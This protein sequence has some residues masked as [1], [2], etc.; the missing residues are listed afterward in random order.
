MLIS[1][2]EF[3][4]DFVSR[5]LYTMMVVFFLAFPASV[6][7][8]MPPPGE[9]EF[10]YEIGGG[11]DIPINAGLGDTA[12]TPYALSVNAN[13]FDACGRFDPR[14][15]VSQMINDFTAKFTQIGSMFT[16]AIAGL[17]GYIFCR[18]NP[19]ACQLQENM[20]ARVEDMYNAGM[21]TCQEFQQVMVGDDNESS[22]WTKS[23]QADVWQSGA[24]QDRD[25]EE[26]SR[27]A[28]RAD[29]SGGVKWVGGIQAGGDD[30][31][32]IRVIA[33]TVVAGYNMQMQRSVLD[34]S[35]VTITPE[36]ATKNHIARFWRSPEEAAKWVTEVVGEVR[37]DI[38]SNPNGT[39]LGSVPDTST[40]DGDSGDGGE[41]VEI[42]HSFLADDM[43]SPAL[44]LM[45]KVSREE[46]PIRQLV[47]D[48]LSTGVMPE[49]D[50]LIAVSGSSS[51]AVIT[52]ELLRALRASPM[53]SVLGG[54]LARD[55]AIANVAQM[56]L[57]ARHVLAAGLSEPGIAA[58]EPAR[59]QIQR[60]M[61]LL[62]SE[63]Q[64]LLTEK[65]VTKLLVS[66]T[67]VSLL[68]NYR[69]RRQT[70]AGESGYDDP[71]LQG[72]AVTD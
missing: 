59:Q 14:Y 44:G 6:Y 3:N 2:E 69:S 54:Q 43:N 24:G 8:E 65:D 27:E 33:D 67:A 18:S 12:F 23:I 48:Y 30:Q 37:P 17:P 47:S 50:E 46:A 45:A 28:S 38:N 16:S 29:G 53:R 56:A 19:L 13:L 61:E 11:L 1:I 60:R 32:P 20:T 35:A 34:R 57:S 21:D 49:N 55:I 22:G 64:M 9:S 40:A 26:V 51:S 70:T 72:G 4:M 10:F 39:A 5:P 36:D 63:I 66:D 7:A 52:P 31:P 58:Y 15:S 42:T 41:D 71:Y 62:D 25:P 68:K